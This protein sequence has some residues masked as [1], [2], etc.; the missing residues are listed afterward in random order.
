[1]RIGDIYLHSLTQTRSVSP[2][3][4][5]TLTHVFAPTANSKSNKVKS[6]VCIIA[7][8]FMIVFHSAD[9][10]LFPSNSTFY[11]FLIFPPLKGLE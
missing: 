2:C 3:C 1:M 7:P 6:G 10:S 8:R 5:V 9:T 11:L 4:R